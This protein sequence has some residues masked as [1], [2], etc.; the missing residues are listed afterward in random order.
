MDSWI[1]SNPGKR[2]TIYDLP[3]VTSNALVNAATPKNI[4][5]GFSVSGVWPFNRNVFD[6]DEYAPSTVTNIVLDS[7]DNMLPNETSDNTETVI[8]NIITETLSQQPITISPESIR[9]YPKAC[10]L[11]VMFSNKGLYY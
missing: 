10:F 7:T 4:I 9:P 1:K 5:N 11:I 6:D 2:F 8:T 3:S